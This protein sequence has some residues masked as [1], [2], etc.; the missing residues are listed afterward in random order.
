VTGIRIL[1]AFA[2]TIAAYACST[3]VQPPGGRLTASQQILTTDAIDRALDDLQWP[4]V[5]GRSV[6]VD[7]GAPA[8]EDERRYLQS[9]ITARIVERGARI[10][11]DLKSADYAFV[12]LA[13][14][15]GIDEHRTFFGI[16]AM[17]SPLL[18]IGVPEVPLYKSD[19]Q[20]GVARLE[21]FLTNRKR[22]GVIAHSPTV[23][24]QTWVRDRTIL[25][26]SMHDGNDAQ[27][28]TD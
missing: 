28:R 4:N 3:T 10:V 11:S 21:T 14:A 6:F 9:A 2:A 18:P 19:R 13:K 27:V 23:S 17:Q 8:A 22:G 25:L 15:V 16:P 20:E 24:A 1:A 5:D 7:I 12:V 26:F